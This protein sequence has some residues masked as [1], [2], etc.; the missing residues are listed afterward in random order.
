[1]VHFHQFLIKSYMQKKPF[2]II[3]LPGNEH[4]HLKQGNDY[5]IKF[6]LIENTIENMF[7]SN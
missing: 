4:F 6:N 1:M 7:L 2:L 5:S 3:N